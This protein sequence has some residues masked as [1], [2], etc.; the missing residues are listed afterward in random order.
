MPLL[1]S[2]SREVRQIAQTALTLHWVQLALNMAWTPLCKSLS[3]EHVLLLSVPAV[4]GLQRTRLALADILVLSGT[5]YTLTVSPDPLRRSHLTRVPMQTLCAQVDKRAFYIHLAYS[6][7][8]TY[9]TYLN[10]KQMKHSTGN[11][12]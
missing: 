3:T 10:G 8:L 4:F 1:Q 5:V 9:A 2:A 6:C 12:C 7:W 11:E